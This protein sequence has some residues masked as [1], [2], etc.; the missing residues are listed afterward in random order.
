MGTTR[1]GKEKQPRRRVGRVISEPGIVHILPYR[2]DG[3]TELEVVNDSSLQGSPTLFGTTRLLYRYTAAGRMLSRSE[4]GV[5]SNPTPT[6]LMYDLPATGLQKSET[7]PASSL[8]DFTYSAESEMLSVYTGPLNST[9]HYGYSLRGEL[10]CLY[11]DCPAS[12]YP[13]NSLMANGVSVKVP[14]P[15]ATRH[16]V[17]QTQWDN[18]MAVMSIKRR[19]AA[20]RRRSPFGGSFDKAGR[21]ASSSGPIGSTNELSVAAR[22]YDAENHLLSTNGLQ[23]CTV[24]GDP[25]SA[26]RWGPNGHPAELSTDYV[27]HSNASKEALHWDANQL[28]FASHEQNG[29]QVL[30]DI[31]IGVQGDVLPH[32]QGYP[33]SRS[34]SAVQ[35]ARSWAVTIATERFLRA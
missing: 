5:G 20:K 10:V 28:L 4:D 25:G 27:Q 15:L 35:G 3:R 31:K 17:W 8:H 21:Q 19:S 18:R 33:D 9:Y 24:A 13:S 2:E 29:Q 26:I 14:L 34:T 6:S 22:C 7:A 23:N 12:P 32:D 11:A 30:D 16:P 1:T